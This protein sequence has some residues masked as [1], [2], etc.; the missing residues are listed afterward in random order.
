MDIRRAVPDD[1][2]RIN[3]LLHQVLEVHHRG[4]PDLFKGGTKKYTD[5]E[6][7]SILADDA[8]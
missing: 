7:L 1:L 4:R 3:A 5:E 2:A 6:L 8:R